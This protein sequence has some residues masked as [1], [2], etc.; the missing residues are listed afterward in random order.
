M[1]HLG[2]IIISRTIYTLTFHATFSTYH[3]NVL[4]HLINEKS[5]HLLV[6]FYELL[7][8]IN[9]QVFPKKYF[10]YYAN[11]NVFCLI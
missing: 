10:L 1:P 5:I 11:L 4:M 7:Y 6:F 3:L 2:L 9:D 8:F